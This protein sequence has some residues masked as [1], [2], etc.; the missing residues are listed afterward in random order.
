MLVPASGM[1]S[2]AERNKN[3]DTTN[4]DIAIQA[5]RDEFG[6][7]V[8]REDLSAYVAKLNELTDAV[9]NVRAPHARAIASAADKASR[10]KKAARIK[11]A[12]VL[13]EEKERAEG[14][15]A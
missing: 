10:E 8:D 12:L 6:A 15:V 7:P 13:L 1:V 5:V 3:M 2:D 4:I 11:A 9:K 14:A